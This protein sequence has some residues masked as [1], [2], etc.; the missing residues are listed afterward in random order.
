M[1]LF[2]TAYAEEMAL[3]LSGKDPRQIAMHLKTRDF[4]PAKKRSRVMLDGF[5]KPR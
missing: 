5:K 3:P 1:R 2:N 4:H